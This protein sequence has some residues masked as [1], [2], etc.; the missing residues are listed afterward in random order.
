MQFTTATSSILL[1]YQGVTGYFATGTASASVTGFTSAFA[2]QS[3][4]VAPE[5][6]AW[7]LLATGL[8]CI[9]LAGLSLQGG[10]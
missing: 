2:V 9:A 3:V 4:S 10:V 5:P 6:E 8:A 7:L 1:G